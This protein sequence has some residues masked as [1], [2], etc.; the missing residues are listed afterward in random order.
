MGHSLTRHLPD[1]I[2]FDLVGLFVHEVLGILKMFATHVELKA[3]GETFDE[4][5]NV[6]SGYFCVVNC[7][8]MA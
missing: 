3:V 2:T 4:V 1:H 5:C 7:S 8:D 6:K